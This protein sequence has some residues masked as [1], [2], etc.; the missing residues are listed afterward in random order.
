MSLP[1]HSAVAATKALLERNSELRSVR[2]HSKS[3]VIIGRL[4][5]SGSVSL[6]YAATEAVLVASKPVADAIRN[7]LCDALNI[8]PSTCVEIAQTQFDTVVV[9]KEEA[10]VIGLEP[11]F[12]KLGSFPTRNVVVTAR[13]VGNAAVFVARSFSPCLGVNE[14]AIDPSTFSYLASYW[15]VNLRKK[16]LTCVCGDEVHDLTLEGMGVQTVTVTGRANVL[17][18]SVLKCNNFLPSMM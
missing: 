12:D 18:D 16:K 1:G 4:T 7:Y 8:C 13:G 10:Q 9:L 11:D 15:H 6:T 5:E 17:V 2:L 3:G 14:A